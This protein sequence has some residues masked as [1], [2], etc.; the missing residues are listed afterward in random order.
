M[1]VLDESGFFNI[2]VN[3]RLSI[4]KQ[5]KAI[6]HELEHIFRDDFF[7]DASLEEIEII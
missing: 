2:Y 7:R 1:T 4:C 5:S 3:S 6:D